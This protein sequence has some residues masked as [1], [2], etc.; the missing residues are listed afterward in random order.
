MKNLNFKLWLPFSLLGVL[1]LCIKLSSLGIRASDTNIYFYTAKELLSGKVLYKDIFFTNF[2]LIP[3]IGALYYLISGGNLLFYYFTASLETLL[4]AGLIYF[5]AY[6]QS[7]SRLVATTT[8]SLYLFSFILLATT[9]HQT[10]VFLA[11]LWITLSYFFLNHRRY[12]LVGVFAALAMLTKA[13]SLP[14]ILSML[15]FLLLK[16]PQQV[17]KFCLGGIMTGFIVLLPS[18]LLAR[19]DLIKDVIFYSLTRSQGLS[20]SGILVFVFQHDFLFVLILIGTI[21]MIKKQLFFGLFSL[22]SILFFTFYKDVYY[23]YLNVTLPILCLAFPV[24]VEFLEKKLSLNRFLIPTIIFIAII[25]NLAT[26]FSG[27]NKLQVLPVNELTKMIHQT[28]AP[29]LYGVNGITPALAYITHKPLL[30]NIVDTNDNI[31][32]KGYLNANTLTMDAIKQHAL[33]VTQG[34]WYPEQGI[35]QDFMTDI[36][37][38]KLVNNNCHMVNR[39]PFRSEGVINSITLSSC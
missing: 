34:V 29:V 35:T 24:S 21:L 25:Y 17:I 22:F 4:T 11:T 20:K 38:T 1:F 39:F 10:G 19:N 28:K 15:V 6:R 36:I 31:F 27:Y 13:Y 37:D 2:P 26:Y 12:L 18:L 3:Y 9:D 30:N 23:L 33:I 7:S 32:R 8:A 5:L 14:L 16:E